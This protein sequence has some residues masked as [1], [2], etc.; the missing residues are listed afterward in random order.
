MADQPAARPPRVSILDLTVAQAAAIEDELSLPLDRWQED[1]PKMR[2]LPLI[3]AAI[4]G[5]DASD[6]DAMTMRD[7]LDRVSLDGEDDGPGNAGAAEASPD[8]P[9]RAA[10]P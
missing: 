1:A 6:Y 3:L 8:S 4:E 5:V 10:G 9:E 2:L 7:M